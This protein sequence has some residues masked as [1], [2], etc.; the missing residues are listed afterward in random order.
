MAGMSLPSAWPELWLFA[1]R[2]TWPPCDD[3]SGEGYALSFISKIPL[4]KRFLNHLK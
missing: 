4:A 3:T 2:L 1:G